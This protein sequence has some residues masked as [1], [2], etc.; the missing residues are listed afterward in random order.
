MV[1]PN[2][3]RSRHLQMRFYPL[4]LGRCIPASHDLATW[5]DPNLSRHGVTIPGRIVFNFWKVARGELSLRTTEFE[6]TVFDIVGKRI[7]RL[8]PERLVK[9]WENGEKQV[10]VNFIKQKSTY[11][12]E[13]VQKMGTIDLG[14]EIASVTG[15]L[16]F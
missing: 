9:W 6:G 16:F 12:A 4:C 14:A 7:P 2:L 3:A 5:R 10:V 15:D 8:R 11:F 1:T 13:L